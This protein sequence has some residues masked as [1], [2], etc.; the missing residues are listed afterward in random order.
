MTPVMEKRVIIVVLSVCFVMPLSAM[1]SQESGLPRAR[2]LGVLVGRL[3][4]G[5]LNAITDVSGVRVGHV[6]MYEGD[7]VRTGVTV[8][9]PHGGNLFQ[10]KV[11]AAVWSW[12]AFGKLAGSTQVRELG[13][14]ETP[15]V[16][17]NTLNV[18]TAI[19]ALVRHT[20]SLPGNEA[21]RSVNAV[22]GETNDGF[23]N[24]IRG[25]HVTEADVLRAIQAA[26]PGGV[27]EGNVGAGTGTRCFGWKGGIGTASRMLGVAGTT[28]VTIGVIIQANFG[29]RLRILGVP[30]PPDLGASPPGPGKEEGSC[31]I[32]VATDAPLSCRNLRRLARR[33]F[34]GLARTREVM[35]GSSGD[36]AIAFTTA[37]RIPHGEQN[38]PVVVPP[39]L[40]NNAM[41]PLF[42]AVEEAVEEAVYNALF[43]AKPM[44]GYR[45]RKLSALSVAEVVSLL[46]QRGAI[47][48]LRKTGIQ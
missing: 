34:A 33:A 23:L 15:V 43:A 29:R 19:T 20:L 3:P 44:K 27:P 35:T 4:T 11:P 16:L 42:Q 17:T 1:H 7:D 40:G 21:V 38:R 25:L 45:G 10:R 39:L 13:N 46:R 6:T 5:A 36:Y 2:D 47:K 48:A 24:D 41:D 31:M 12:N 8:I 22:V 37:W 14:L 32:V 18:G 28:P 9:L 30:I 26:R